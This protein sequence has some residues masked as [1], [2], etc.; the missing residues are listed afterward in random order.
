MSEV[1]QSRGDYLR[2]VIY[3]QEGYIT[4][5]TQKQNLMVDDYQDRETS[6]REFCRQLDE[7]KELSN[8][9]N[10]FAHGVLSLPEHSSKRSQDLKRSLTDSEFLDQKLREIRKAF[11]RNLS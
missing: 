11:V 3:L 9:R 7:F 1:Y 2:A 8:I 4:A 10:A 6:K 5:M